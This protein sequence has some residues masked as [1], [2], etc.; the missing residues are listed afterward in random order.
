MMFLCCVCPRVFSLNKYVLGAPGNSPEELG[1]GGGTT[2]HAW[3]DFLESNS[4]G[5]FLM[6]KILHLITQVTNLINQS[7]K[8]ANF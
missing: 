7:S 5:E 1:Q 4:R 6:N 3:T 2:G 8:W